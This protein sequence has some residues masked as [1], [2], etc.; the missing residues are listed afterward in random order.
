MN[1]SFLGD[2]V[3]IN[4][5]KEGNKVLAEIVYILYAKQIK[6]LQNEGLW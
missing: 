3:V 1:F 6:Y 5:I 4:P 2:Y